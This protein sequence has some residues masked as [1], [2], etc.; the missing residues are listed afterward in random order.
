LFILLWLIFRNL[1]TTGELVSMQF[2]TAII[3]GPL[4]DLGTIIVNYREVEASVSNFDLLM[5]KPIEERPENPIEIDELN[6][7][8]FEEVVFHHRTARYNAIDGISFHVKVR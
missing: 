2:I 1:L 5:Q 3:F 6:D 7:I 4:Q 8:R